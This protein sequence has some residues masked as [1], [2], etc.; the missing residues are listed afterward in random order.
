MAVLR[1][2]HFLALIIYFAEDVISQT[3]KS[4]PDSPCRRFGHQAIA[5]KDTL[6][7]DGGWTYADQLSITPDKTISM[8]WDICYAIANEL[9]TA[10]SFSTILVR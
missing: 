1:L 10:M 8:R 2:A 6:Y 9:K 7:V 3:S 5:I 4:V